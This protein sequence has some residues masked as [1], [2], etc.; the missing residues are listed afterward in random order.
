M[1]RE[2]L[3]SRIFITEPLQMQNLFFSKLKE[4]FI[5]LVHSFLKKGFKKLISR[6][7]VLTFAYKSSCQGQVLKL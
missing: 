2:I 3:K 5:Q 6:Q 7:K 4:T 1:A